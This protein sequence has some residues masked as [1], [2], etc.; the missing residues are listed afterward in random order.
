MPTNADRYPTGA[1]APAPPVLLAGAAQQPASGGFTPS[2]LPASAPPTASW[3]T[4]AAAAGAASPHGVPGA[5]GDPL[6]P[7]AP[8]GTAGATAGSGAGVPAGVLTD[9]LAAL[10]IL[11]VLVLI[12]CGRRRTSWF[13]E[14]VIGPD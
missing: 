9:P 14:V 7:A 13:P 4:D 3:L 6:A 1:S 5:P 10:A 12:A 2:R 11:T 8:A